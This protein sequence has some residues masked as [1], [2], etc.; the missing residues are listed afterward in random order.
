M[1]KR[2]RAVAYRS[3]APPIAPRSSVR[4]V[5]ASPG[6]KLKRP[7]DAARN[8]IPPVSSTRKTRSRIAK[9]TDKFKGRHECTAV[10]RKYE[11][12]NVDNI[13]KRSDAYRKYRR[14][15]SGI[16]S[17]LGGEDRLTTMEHS[18]IQAYASAFVRMNDLTARQL[19]GDEYVEF[20]DLASAISS[21]V[22]VAH[23]LGI[24]RRPR[25]VPPLSSYLNGQPD[26]IEGEVLDN[27]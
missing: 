15:V 27:E 16:T 10:K 7:E 4:T 8:I 1:R 18:L 3:P 13:D 25:E 19:L 22:R 23:R 24:Q 11:L 5:K 14:I 21:M 20:N 2:P 17:D 6:R 9:G 12:I 26:T